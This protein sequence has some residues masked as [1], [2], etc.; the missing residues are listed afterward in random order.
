MGSQTEVGAGLTS[1]EEVEE[2]GKEESVPGMMGM[3]SASILDLLNPAGAA[4]PPRK[5]HNFLI[6]CFSFCLCPDPH[7]WFSL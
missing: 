4:F 1:P 3:I 6:S 2:V 7:F 5:D